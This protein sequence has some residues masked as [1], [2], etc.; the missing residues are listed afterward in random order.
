M[1]KKE[2]RF[3]RVRKVKREDEMGVFWLVLVVKEEKESD[4]KEARD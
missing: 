4:V 1:I 3:E 2:C